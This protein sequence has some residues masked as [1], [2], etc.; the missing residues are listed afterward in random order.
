[1]NCGTQRLAVTFSAAMFRSVNRQGTL[2]GNFPIR[3]PCRQCHDG[4]WVQSRCMRGCIAIISNWTLSKCFSIGSI[5]MKILHS[6]L[7]SSTK[8]FEYHK[9]ICSLHYQQNSLASICHVII[10]VIASNACVCFVSMSSILNS[11]HR[12]LCIVFSSR[13]QSKPIRM[14][15]KHISMD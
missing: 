12:S 4:K 6:I 3:L 1:M 7:V 15:W 14:D 11:C 9:P 13:G 8:S 5:W 10:G 2:T